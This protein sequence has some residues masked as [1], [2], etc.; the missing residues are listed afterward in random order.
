MFQNHKNGQTTHMFN[1]KMAKLFTNLRVIEWSP[2]SPWL[3]LYVFAR[4]G[5]HI[6]R[7]IIRPII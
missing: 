5:L 7:L 3:L 6:E 1:V 4:I 2:S